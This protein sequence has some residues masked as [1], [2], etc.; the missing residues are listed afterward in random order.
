MRELRRG[1]V[2]LALLAAACAT[3]P[4]AVRYPESRRADV[5]D[6]YFG[7][8]VADPYRWLEDLDSAETRAWVQSQNG[9]SRPLLDALPARPAIHRRLGELLSFERYG[10]PQRTP[11]GG[12]A[13][14]RNDGLQNQSVLYF[15]DNPG[16]RPRVLI[17]PNGWSTDGTE[18]MAD[19]K[20]SPD[21]RYVLF[22]V[23]SGGS[24]WVEYRVLDVAT[25]KGLPDR[26]RG[27]N[28]N[29]DFSRIFWR[30]GTSGFF[31][32]RFPD[33]PAS[34][35]GSPPAITHQ[36]VYFH[37]LGTDQKQDVRVY[38]RPDQPTWFAWGEATEDGRYLL[39]YVERTEDTEKQLYVRDLGDPQ[40]PRLDAPL[41]Q[42]VGNWDGKY[43]LVGNQGPVLFLRTSAGA[44][45]YR[46]VA[47]DVRRP[48]AVREVVPESADVMQDARLIGGEIVVSYLHDAAA[49]LARYSTR[50]EPRGDIA[51]P[52]LGSAVG[53]TGRASQPWLAYSFA[54]FAQPTTV[55]LHDLATRKSAPFNPPRLAFSPDDYVTQ[56]V[57]VRSKDGTRVPMFLSHRRDLPRGPAPTLLYGYG[58][59]A[60]AQTPSFSPA[61]LVWMERGGIH[62]LV[63]LRGGNEYGETW[64]QAGMLDRK[65]NVFDDFIAAAEFLIAERRT[66]AA[67]LAIKGRSNGG[68]LIG[69]VLNQRPELFAAANAGV[70]VLDMLRYHKFGIAYAWA[71]DWGTSESA[72]GFRTLYAYSPV[73]HVHSG[74]HYPAVLVTTAERDDRV[75]PLHSF[76]YTAALQ[77][78]QAGD[79]P[80]LIRVETRA[81]HGGGTALSKQIEENAD[82]LAFFER[83]TRP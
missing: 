69:A 73:H 81:G 31:Y 6:D 1:P 26:V 17:D 29:F 9:V 5:V 22:A 75:H 39:V 61:T 10:V 43:Y 38:Q 4:A 65:Q 40:R 55:Y 19:W 3:L 41:R 49:R 57:F 16:A 45:R 74:A 56:Q 28:F 54:S 63:G 15:Q 34:A 42:L 2:A 13:Y 77:A 18:A 83:Y 11:A 71:G 72:A 23:Q 59:F 53:L 64:H 52:G 27:V 51:L 32:S 33:P 70:G 8:K 44:S 78:A 37:R 62:A 66:T 30:G 35:P 68:L 12:L 58:G 79:R 80:V 21:G 48:H 46:I 36:K 47:I 60:N 7:T 25:G 14:T 76:K 82:V 20:L 24:D 67:Q 50:G